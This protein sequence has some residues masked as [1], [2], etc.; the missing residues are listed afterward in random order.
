L[1]GEKSIAGAR[2]SLDVWLLYRGAPPNPISSMS[3][4]IA[5]ARIYARYNLRIDTGDAEGWAGT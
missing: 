1:F 3:A 2:L 4:G 5:S